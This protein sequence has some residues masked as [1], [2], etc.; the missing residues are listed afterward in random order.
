MPKI[1]N[2]D[3]FDVWFPEIPS[4]RYE[5]VSN[6]LKQRLSF[7][8]KK[9]NVNLKLRSFL[10]KLKFE[11]IK[12]DKSVFEKKNECWLNTVFLNYAEVVSV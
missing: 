9:D 5:A 8:L 3:L 4:K 2:K 10:N 12:K 6:Y 7:S 11:L 1:L